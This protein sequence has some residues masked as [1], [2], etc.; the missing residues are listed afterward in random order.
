M[1]GVPTLCFAIEHLERL[2]SAWEGLPQRFGDRGPYL[3]KYT[4][5][6]IERAVKYYKKMDDSHAY[7]L[8]MCAY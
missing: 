7:I 6:G 4:R 5:I 3:E 1:K 2:M 8:S